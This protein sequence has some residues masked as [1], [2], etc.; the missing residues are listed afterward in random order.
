[1]KIFKLDFS[2][3]RNEAHY[4]FYLEVKKLFVKFSDVADLIGSLYDKLLLLIGLEAQLVDEVRTSEFTEQIAEADRRRDRAITGISAAVKSFL[5][6]YEP[7]KVTA[8]NAIEIRLKAFRGSIKEKSYE[9]ESAAVN[10]LI[11]DLTTTYTAQV[12]LLALGGWITELTAAQNDFDRTFELRIDEQTHKPQEKLHQVRLQVDAAYSAATAFI[13]A[14]TL[15]D[16]DQECGKFIAE[17]NTLIK[18]YTDHEI[19]HAKKIDIAAAEPAP[20]PPQPYT[21]QPCTPAPE[22]LLVTKDDGTV[23]L[24]LGKDYNLTFKNNIEVGNAECTIHG[25]NA[26]RGSKTVTF[27]IIRN[28]PKNTDE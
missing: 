14:Y 11:T 25:K 20:I 4:R 10:V 28:A 9:E 19:H 1:M 22:V 6:H 13:D 27:I 3:L 12:T 24:E 21:G 5:H 23:K 8:A 26:Y 18:Y 15:I 16:G 7:D 17:L 2:R